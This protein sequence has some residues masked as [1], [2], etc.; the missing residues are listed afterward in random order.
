MTSKDWQDGFRALLP[1]VNVSF[2]ALPHQDGGR[3]A[4]GGGT[5]AGLPPHLVSGQESVLET[6]GSSR[7]NNLPTSVG[8]GGGNSSNSMLNEVLGI[9]GSGGHSPAA[10]NHLNGHLD[11]ALH[12]QQNIRQSSGWHGMGGVHN[13]QSGVNDWGVMDPAIVSGQLSDPVHHHHHH[14]PH[15]Q[16]MGGHHHQHHPHHR[17]DSPP[18]WIKANLEQ[19]TSDN[20]GNSGGSSFN[21]GPLLPNAFSN[22]NLSSPPP[23]GGPGGSGVQSGQSGSAG[24]QQSNGQSGNGLAGWLANTPPPGFSLNSRTAAQLQQQQQQQHPFQN[25][26]GAGAVTASDLESEFQRLIHS[27]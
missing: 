22:F 26:G 21:I 4:S 16:H 27:K 8:G 1:N 2:G 23:P 6:G 7:F 15:Q 14:H 10:T 11:R 9:G 18:N 19:L 12:H 24:M 17:T 5:S 25:M 3:S 13:Q 20:G